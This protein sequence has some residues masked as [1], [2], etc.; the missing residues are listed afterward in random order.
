MMRPAAINAVVWEIEV[1]GVL[2]LGHFWDALVGTF[3]P[4]LNVAHPDLVLIGSKTV[5]ACQESA[6]ATMFL[7]Q[8]LTVSDTCS[9]P[10]G[11]GC[12]GWACRSSRGRERRAWWPRR[13]P[14]STRSPGS[15]CTE[16]KRG[17][18]KLQM[19][20]SSLTCFPVFNTSGTSQFCF[21][22]QKKKQ[23]NSP[24]CSSTGSSFS[25]MEEMF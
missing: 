3:T 7:L 21:S 4:T 13:P 22:V 14:G 18:K 19:K 20:Q 6:E 25:W 10:P 5:A 9:W 16:S 8:L 17:R 2:V 24:R 11:W 12:S 23:K 1:P 15:P